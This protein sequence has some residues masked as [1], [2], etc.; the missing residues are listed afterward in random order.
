MSLVDRVRALLGDDAVDVAA[1]PDGVPRVAPGSPDAVGLLLGT[2]REEGWRVRV[3][4]AGTWLPADA[5]ADLALTTRRLDK[6]PAIEPQDLSATAEAGI[7]CDLL[8]QQLADRGTWLA[9]DP[10]GLAGRTLGSVVATATA[11]PLRHGFGAVRDHLLGVTFV[12]GDGRLVQ[13]GGRVMKNVA[14]YDLTKLE[15]GGFGAFGVIVLVHLRLRALPRVDQTSLL[16]GTREDLTQVAEDVA[17]AGLQPAA[18]ELMSPALARRDGWALAVRLAGSAALV[19][20]EEAGLRGASGG[21]FTALRAEEAHGFWMRAAESFA[22]RPITFRTGGL[23][24]SSDELLDLLQHQVGDEWVSAS[25]GVGAIRWAGDTTV[26][27]LRRLRRTLAGLEVPL[28]L[29]R[30]PWSIRSA[31]GHFGAYREGVGPLVAGLRRTFDP[32]EALDAC[33]HCGFCLQA[34]PT[35]LATGDEA[36]SPRGRIEL[37]RA[38]EAGDLAPD[39]PALALHLDRC[40]GCRGCEP[41]CPSGVGYGRGLAAARAL[42]AD[43]RGVPALAR[44]ALAAMTG[45]GVSRVVYALARALR[46]TGIPRWL[47]GWGRVRFAMGMLAATSPKVGGGRWRSVKGGGGSPARNLHHPP[48]TSTTST[49]LLFRGCVMEGLFSHVHDATIRTLEVNGYAVREVPEQV[50]CGALHE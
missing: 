2:A 35:F 18:L 37:M 21:R 34:C 26:D 47:S 11:G 10:P 25:P 17:A 43:R 29:E 30:A 36:D 46:A 50:C 40:L 42:I 45:A 48:P 9:L 14:G 1:T 8:R 31:V 19:A 3:E 13:S 22:T 27:R 16:E 12:T 28:T 33:V 41:V 4:G 49:V 44:L 32:G 38:L 39:D 7:G 24:D 6:I 20:A 15:A 5:P 23:P